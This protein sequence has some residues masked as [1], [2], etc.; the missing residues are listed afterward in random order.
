MMKIMDIY[1]KRLPSIKQLQYFIAVCEEMSFT[2]AAKKLGMSQPPLTTQ[3]KILEETLQSTLFLRNSHNITLTQEGE[4]LKSQ[5]SQLLNDL[6]SIVNSTKSISI[7]KVMI[8]TTKTL[9]FDYIPYFKLFLSKFSEHAEIYQHNY[10]SKELL[11][12]LQQGNIDFAI[13]SDYPNRT[14]TENSLLIYQESMTLVLPANHRCNK[15]ENIDLNDL[16]DL[17]LFWFKQ[18]LNPFFYEQ[19]ENV[20]NRLDKPIIRRAELADNLSML[21]EVALGKGM[22]LLPQSMAQA[23]VDGVSYKKLNPHQDKKL[24]I[25]IYLVW[26]KNLKITASNQAIIDFFTQVKP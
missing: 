5:V 17:P 16:T 1:S 10:I 18:H 3:I 4:I 2:R 11:R 15:Q 12:E 20:F 14:F 8:G 7:K 21:L 23:K 25:N 13:V 26:R 24:K 6:C 22:M 9:N 19:C